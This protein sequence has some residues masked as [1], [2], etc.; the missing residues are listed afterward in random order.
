MATFKNIR[1][2]AF[3]ATIFRAASPFLARGGKLRSR[4]MTGRCQLCERETALTRHHLVPQ[5]RHRNRWNKKNFDR[6]VVKTSLLL[7]CEGCHKQ[8]HV[9]FTEKEL[10]RR[11]SDLPRLLAEPQVQR[12]VAWIKDKPQGFRPRAN[13]SRPRRARR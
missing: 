7:V 9:L 8:L 1:V 11:L 4:G 2:R 10:E 5:C 3:D 12:F 13:R 6:R